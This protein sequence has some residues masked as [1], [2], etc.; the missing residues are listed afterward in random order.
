MILILSNNPLSYSDSNGRT[1]ANMFLS[2]KKEEL[3][4][5]F[6]SGTPETKLANFIQ[7]TDKDALLG[8]L[9]DHIFG[10][11]SKTCHQSHKSAFKVFIREFIWKRSAV[12]KKL[13]KKL[14]AYNIT[15]I[16]VQLGD[17][18]F[19]I[20]LGIH[21]ARELNLRLITF[22]TEDYYFKTWNYYEKRKEGIIFRR[23][24]KK[25]KKLVIRS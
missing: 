9:K 7:I 24:Q 18:S 16:F 19:I 8:T 20:D 2:Y 14:S 11:E 13:I 21:I 15:D 5:V 22:N 3:L 4:N 25:L 1:I 10:N 17:Y 6:I 23:H 12:K